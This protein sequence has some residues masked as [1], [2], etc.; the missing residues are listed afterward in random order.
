L[1]IAINNGKQ[2]DE[3]VGGSLSWLA[4]Y[5]RDEK[6]G[7]NRTI[8]INDDPRWAII[9]KRNRRYS[10]KAIENL[11]CGYCNN[12]DGLDYIGL[13]TVGNLV[14]EIIWKVNNEQSGESGTSSTIPLLSVSDAIRVHS[15]KVKT[16]GRIVGVSPLYDVVTTISWDCP[17][18]GYE[19]IDD[20][21]P[22]LA[23]FNPPHRKCPMCRFGNGNGNGNQQK[24]NQN[25]V[26]DVNDLIAL[27]EYENA[28]SISFQDSE[29]RD[30]LEKLHVVLLGDENTRN[31]RVGERVI[32][33]GDMYVLSAGGGGAANSSS[34]ISKNSRA[35]L[36]PVLYA[37]SIIYEREE[38]EK[39]ITENDIEGFKR[40][41]EK[42]KLIDR[43]V[44][45]F[46][47]N[48]IGHSDAKLGILR[49]AVSTKN[50]MR[51]NSTTDIRNRT[52]TLLAGDPGTAKSMLAEE[53]TDILHDSRYVTA[54]HA[55]AKSILAIIDK[56]PDN[57]KMLLL[58]AV[59]MSKHSIC[60]INEIGSMPY[61]DQQ[62]FADVLE[63]GK[64]TIAKHGVYQEI[65]SPT[66]II[67]TTNSKG[68]YWNDSSTPSIDEIPIKSNILDRFDQ[69][70]IFKDF[71]TV[72]ERRDYVNRKME[73][74]QRGIIY[75]Y[76]FLKR[77]LEYASSL[78][79]PCMTEEASVMLS[80]FWIRLSNE[81]HAANRSLDSLV[82][83]AKA[84][85]R[86]HLKE[87]VDTEIANEVIQSIGLTLT[88]FGKVI[89]T[90][91][92]DPR[93]MAYNEIIEYVNTLEVPITFIEAAKYVCAHNN[94]LKQYFGERLTS[95]SD[96]RKLRAVHDLLSDRTG[97][98][99]R[100]RS[101]LSVAI[102][103]ISPLTL[104]KSRNE[105]EEQEEQGQSKEPEEKTVMSFKSFRS[106]THHN[107]EAEEANDKSDLYVNDT[108][109]LIDIGQIEQVIGKA[110]Q[111]NQGRNKGYF[112][113]KDWKTALMCL[114]IQDP[115]YCDED[116]A[117]QMLY[118]LLEEGKLQEIESGR[119]GPGI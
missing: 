111:D 20:F 67:A 16:L 10:Q 69:I 88:E 71:Q 18:C 1:T 94:A 51:A 61:E 26:N 119:Y 50:D 87:V 30:D 4:Y 85:A 98:N 48:V 112:D 35:R 78:K 100:S 9:L 64:F 86:L 74:N 5:L 24:P 27:P 11:V 99:K 23:F 42:P 12:H 28:K 109:D 34:G 89:D 105:E 117:E 25:D 13:D 75:N 19:T 77:Y 58:G 17:A 36:Y 57:T 63:E 106:F 97:T 114:P 73:M 81:V 118:A 92:A 21:D 38:E 96:N 90:V 95:I 72:E 22:P 107:K 45:I 46:A 56:E 60:A 113:M 116:Q 52:H 76:I 103:G 66:T 37:D 2:E 80:E 49:S 14:K 3:T 7:S 31:V 43:L 70:Y 55:S 115:Y 68:G 47:P 40:F 93:D 82:R 29:P 108:N 83:I 8:R 15:G 59:P 91:V 53:G 101:G 65:D 32:I 54:Q 33:M 79:K 110:M 62:Y 44:S 104:V 84:Q 41:A 6:N 102:V 39:P